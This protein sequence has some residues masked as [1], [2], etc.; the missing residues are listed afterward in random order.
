MEI[1]ELVDYLNGEVNVRSADDRLES[2][3]E[4]RT[5]SPAEDWNLLRSVII[6]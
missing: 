1:L 2:A 3:E 4:K 5:A 6:C